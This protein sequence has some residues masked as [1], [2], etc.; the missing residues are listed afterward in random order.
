M[1]RN[2]HVMYEIHIHANVML[3]L[4]ANMIQYVIAIQEMPLKAESADV[5]VNQE[6]VLHIVIAMLVVPAILY[7]NL[8]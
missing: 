7:L 1:V 3:A 5:I 6:A 8:L 2:A 4:A